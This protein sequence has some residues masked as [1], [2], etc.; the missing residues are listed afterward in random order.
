LNGV[1]DSFAFWGSKAKPWIWEMYKPLLVHTAQ[2]DTLPFTMLWRKWD[3]GILVVYPLSAQCINDVS[4]IFK[5][6]DMWL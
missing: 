6:Y 1:D 5:P 4:T 3:V 2:Y